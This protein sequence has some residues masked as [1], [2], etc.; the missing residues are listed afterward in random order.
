MNLLAV[1]YTHKM[2]H[3]NISDD[4]N[5]ITF[6]GGAPLY[7]GDLKNNTLMNCYRIF[8]LLKVSFCVFLT[9]IS[10]AILFSTI[11]RYST[12][13]K[14]YLSNIIMQITPK[15]NFTI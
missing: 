8:S 15:Y 1:F 14:L 12:T 5:F 13:N 3:F 2:H 4:L 9:R 11:D 6:K 7:L 10:I